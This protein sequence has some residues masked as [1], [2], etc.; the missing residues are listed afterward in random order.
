MIKKRFVRVSP[1]IIAVDYRK[2]D[3]LNKALKS[4]ENAGAN[5]VHLDVMDGKFVKNRTFD[6][7][8]VEKVR[9]K[10][11]MIL[12]VHLMVKDPESEIDK[13]AK[14]GADII[15]VHYEACRD[16]ITALKKIKTKSLLAGIAINPETP[17]LKIKDLI[18]SRL[19]DVVTVMSVNP[20]A[21]GQPFIPKT[22][23]KI[24][25]IRELNK[26]IFIEVDG[27]VNQKNSAYL[28]KL[29]VNIFV[30]GSCIFKSKNM[31]K[32][33][34]EFK[35]KTFKSRVREFFAKKI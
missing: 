24:S 11:N 34:D 23:E 30:S 31:K 3:V 4:I 29:G 32:T 20:G 6:H 1:S 17:V 16:I 18:E 14:A 9:Q 2:E 19:V 10:T 15:T 7:T 12:D 8:F 5:F 26:K 21:C 28:R 27:G 33:I 25:E 22:V 13:Y 35:G